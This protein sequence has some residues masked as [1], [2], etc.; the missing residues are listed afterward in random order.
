MFHI[1]HIEG[2]SFLYVQILCLLNFKE[3]FDKVNLWKSNMIQRNSKY[4]SIVPLKTVLS[5]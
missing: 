5:S 4:Y 1:Y 3:N 2:Q